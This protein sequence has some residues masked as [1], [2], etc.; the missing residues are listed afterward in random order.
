[1][2]T[3]IRHRS[4]T[5]YLVLSRSGKRVW[6]SL[7]TRDR[8]TAYQ[9]FLKHEQQPEGKEGLTLVRAQGLFL[10]FVETNLS[11]GALAVYRNVFSQ[12]NK[13]VIDRPISEITPRDIDFYKISR[14]KEVSPATVNHE[15]RGLRA[16]FN[17][18]IV[19][20]YLEKNPCEGIK[21][22]REVEKLPLYLTK[23]DLAKLLEQTRGNNFTILS[24][25]PQ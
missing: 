8:K 15:L 21:D 17:R 10:P 24:S 18:L 7:R 6:R 4:G 20:E 9:M 1:M 2:S 14:I 25:L 22:I 3:L 13:R 16:F 12:F 19:W 23:E 11:R 5:Y